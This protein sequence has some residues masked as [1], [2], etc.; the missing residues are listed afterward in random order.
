VRNQQRG[1]E[2]KDF[3]S[4][5][6]DGTKAYRTRTSEYE[7]P[8]ALQPAAVFR[9]APE[10]RGVV[11]L[12]RRR[13]FNMRRNKPAPIRNKIDLTDARQVRVLKKRLGNF[14]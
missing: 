7:E 1:R 6:I 2:P 10:R 3:D 8:A 4:G 12:V 5:T 13:V 11:I 9:I 14:R